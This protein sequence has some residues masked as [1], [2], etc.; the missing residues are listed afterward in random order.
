MMLRARKMKRRFLFAILSLSG[1][2]LSSCELFETNS[3][4]SKGSEDSS[5]HGSSDSSIEK[6]NSSSDSTNDSLPSSSTSDSEGNSSSSSDFS[7]EDDLGYS[8]MYFGTERYLGDNQN[9]DFIFDSNGLNIVSMS[10]ENVFFDAEE[11]EPTSAIRIGSSNDYGILNI[12]FEEPMEIQ[13]VYLMAF[14]DASE[15]TIKCAV[16]SSSLSTSL[17][18]NHPLP[19]SNYDYHSAGWTSFSFH[20]D[21]TSFLSLSTV[22]ERSDKCVFLSKVVIVSKKDGNSSGETS[23]ESSQGSSSSSSMSQGGHPLPDGAYRLPRIK[24]SGNSADIYQVNRLSGN[25]YSCTVAKTITKGNEYFEPEDIAAYYQ[26]F[27]SFPV[28]YCYGTS[29]NAAKDEALGYGKNGR[30]YFQYRYGS[31]HKNDYTPPLGPWFKT[32][33]PYY[34]LDIS[35]TSYNPNYNNGKRISRGTYRIVI[36]P[37]ESSI[38]YPNEDSYDSICF[39]TKDHYDTFV[40]YYNYYDGWGSSFVGAN[41]STRPS[42][43]TIPLI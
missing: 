33:V 36:L 10:S 31:Y 2:L 23:S 7:D 34:E 42:V 1:C 21:S 16:A 26:A 8:Y 29:S 6:E 28:N 38:S 9:G 43:T 17:K 27:D 35:T 32:G 15:V 5:F 11:K 41:G 18:E 20:G 37:K 24:V 39:F 4:F 25:T 12:A 3:S 22:S 13:D 14:T 30:C 19:A 40:E